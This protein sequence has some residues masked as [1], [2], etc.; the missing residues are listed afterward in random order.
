MCKQGERQCPGSSSC[1]RVGGCYM[2]HQMRINDGVSERG[3]RMIHFHPA[4]SRNLFTF[5]LT[6]NL[7]SIRD[8]HRFSQVKRERR[9]LIYLLY[10]YIQSI[11]AV[12]CPP[13]SYQ[14]LHVFMHITKS[15]IKS[16]SN[17][18]QRNQSQLPHPRHS[19]L[20]I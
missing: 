11:R 13:S 4:E 10:I 16:T 6:E 9:S 17:C 1:T 19:R 7:N 18:R 15:L 14:G 5:H 20:R 3:V 2:K 8:F 12:D